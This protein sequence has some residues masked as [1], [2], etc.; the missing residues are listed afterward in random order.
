LTALAVRFPT[1][2]T[3]LVAIAAGASAEAFP[4]PWASLRGFVAS[5]VT[6]AA[7]VMWRYVT[8]PD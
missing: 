1:A 5:A 2:T 3:F 7:Y 8:S 4:I 6:I